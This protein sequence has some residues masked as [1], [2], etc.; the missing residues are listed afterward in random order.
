MQNNPNN[1]Y[2]DDEKIISASGYDTVIDVC[3]NGAVA[4]D[5]DGVLCEYKYSKKSCNGVLPCPND[6]TLVEDYFSRYDVYAMYAR[7]IK[8][9]QRLIANLPNEKVFVI[10]KSRIC[11]HKQ[12]LNFL[13]NNYPTIKTENIFFV[14]DYA[15]KVTLLKN[16]ASTNDFI[17]FV[18][19]VPE[20]II[21]AEDS[22]KNLVGIHISAFIE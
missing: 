20:N 16:I 3:K 8:T 5:L 17:A 11:Q 1:F 18:E 12:K 9:M 4:F 7:P 10:S 14:N 6:D 19:D 21:M 13:K 15:D 2:N 22:I